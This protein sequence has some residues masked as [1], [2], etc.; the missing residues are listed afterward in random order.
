MHSAA[1]STRCCC[2]LASSRPCY[3]PL[4]CIHSNTLRAVCSC[5]A[6]GVPL[7]PCTL[8]TCTALPVSKAACNGVK[9][10]SCASLGISAADNRPGPVTQQRQGTTLQSPTTPR[11]SFVPRDASPTCRLQVNAVCVLPGA[12]RVW[13]QLSARCVLGEATPPRRPPTAP[14]AALVC[15]QGKRGLSAAKRVPRGTSLGLVTLLTAPRVG[16]VST[17]QWVA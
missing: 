4:Y 11:Q 10:A 15:L 2:S 16:Q 13:E 3:L 8:A 14:C 17:H 6:V 9:H 7:E 12:S 5:F 1:A